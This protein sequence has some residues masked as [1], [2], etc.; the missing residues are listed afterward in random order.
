M[1]CPVC[2]FENF[3]AFSTCT[4]CGKETTPSAGTHGLAESTRLE[5]TISTTPRESEAGLTLDPTI[6]RM[7]AS[8]LPGMRADL[9]DPV[10][11]GSPTALASL[12]KAGFW[13]RCVAFLVDVGVVALLGTG[14]GMLVDL[15]ARIGGMVS[16]APEAALEWLSNRATSLLV[17]LIALC[18]FTLFVGMGGQTPGKMLLGLK[19]VRAD[20]EA[21]GIGRALVR[22]MGQ[23]LS[24]LLLGLGFLMVGLSGRKQG[25]HDKIAGTYIVRHPS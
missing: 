19:V 9:P 14:G 8:P 2:G 23:C 18:Y 4:Q 7:S 3:D 25:L 6:N 17:V 11:E 10:A 1:R 5:E 13:L 20:G 12:P 22:W 15:S 21:V 24:L 16:S